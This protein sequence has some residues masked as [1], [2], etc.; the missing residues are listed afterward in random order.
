MSV[1]IGDAALRFFVASLADE[2]FRLEF[3]DGHVTAHVFSMFLTLDFRIESQKNE[4][5]TFEGRKAK[6]RQNWMADHPW[7]FRCLRLSVD[8][9]SV[10][11]FLDW[12]KCNVRGFVKRWAQL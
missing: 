7:C 4:E 11:F 8:C 2:Q 3:G 9:L 6:F 10:A 1:S 5:L 12:P